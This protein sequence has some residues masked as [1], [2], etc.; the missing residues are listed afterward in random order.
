MRYVEL[1]LLKAQGVFADGSDRH[2]HAVVSNLDWDAVRLLQWHRE[3]AGTVEHAHDE[4]KNGLAAGHMPSQWFAINAT[5]LK[6]AI[7]SYNIASAIKGLCFSPEE[8]T[9]RAPF[10]SA[11]QP[12]S[13]HHRRHHHAPRTGLRA[14]IAACERPAARFW[15]SCSPALQRNLTRH[16]LAPLRRHPPA[17]FMARGSWWR[18]PAALGEDLGRFHELDNRRPPA[19]PGGKLVYLPEYAG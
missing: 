10:S 2:H 15:A 11:I 3:K 18:P 6:L 9:A 13:Q 12:R 8:R 17:C 7:L 14:A 5:W 16:R 1:R 19:R 4:F